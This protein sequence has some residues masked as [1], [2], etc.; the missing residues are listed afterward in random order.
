MQAEQITYFIITL[1]QLLINFMMLAGV[2][3]AVMKVRGAATKIAEI[4]DREPLI[5][6]NKG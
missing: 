2:M 3:G 1:I 6:H 4:L 5:K